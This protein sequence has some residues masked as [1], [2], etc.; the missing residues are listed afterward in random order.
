MLAEIEDRLV[1]I[2][3]ERV[4]EI[5]KDNIVLNME[6][7]KSPAVAISNLNFE[8]ENMGLVENIDEGN[9]K[10]EDWFSSD[11]VQKSYK[12]KERPLQDTVRV[13]CPPGT[14]LAER[15]DFDVNYGEGLIDFSKAP[16]KGKNKLFVKYLS[17]KKTMTVKGLR[18]KGTYVIDVLHDDRPKVDALAEKVVKALLLVEDELVAEGIELKPVGGETLREQGKKTEKIRLKYSF[19]KE[20]RVK[21]IIPPIEKISITR[22]SV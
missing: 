2:L 20:L 21:K 22:K 16:P 9:I 11:G 6:P 8:F 1:K 3:Q 7:V 5:P 10:L 4:K 14:S 13:D 18:I 12:L 17:H 19:E 15:K